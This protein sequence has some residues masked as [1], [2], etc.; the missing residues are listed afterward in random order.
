MGGGQKTPTVQNLPNFKQA[1]SSALSGTDEMAAN[2]LPGQL[3]PQF[4]S[5]T[6]S[7]INNPGN[8]AGATMGMNAAND[9]FSTGQ[10]LTGAGMSLVP[11][12]TPIMNAAF[13]PQQDLYKQQYQQMQD[14]SGVNNARN[15]VAGTPYGAGLDNQA[16]INF[17]N[18]WQN[19]QLQRMVTGAQGAE[20]LIN[21]GA[22]GAIAGQSLE[23]GAGQAYSTAANSPYNTSLQ[24]LSTLSGQG[25]Q[26]Q[27]IPQQSINDYLAYVGKG[28]TQEGLGLQAQQQ[29]YAQN[30]QTMQGIGSLGMLGA[31]A[32]L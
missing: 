21:T 14:Q 9:Q 29:Q 28:Q 7:I 2:N 10:Q 3:T 30:A 23:G 5:A 20:G 1:A 15:G 24:A 27:Q 25:I 13:D 4:Q 12:A 11:Y 8:Q 17:N 16:S 18:Q 26:A 22:Q 19:Q 31:L 6:N 32:F